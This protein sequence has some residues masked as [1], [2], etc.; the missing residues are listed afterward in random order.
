MY[1]W[2]FPGARLSNNQSVRGNH[3]KSFDPFTTKH[4]TYFFFV[5]NI[6]LFDAPKSYLLKVEDI[7]VDKVVKTRSWKVFTTE[8]TDEFKE[9]ILY[10]T[11]L[12]NANVA[13][14]SIPTVQSNQLFP[15][16]WT[17][18]ASMVST[19]SMILSL[20]SIIMGLL[21]VKQQRKGGQYADEA[22]TF[23]ETRGHLTRGSE[24]LAILLSLPYIFLMFA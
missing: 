7:Y 3:P 12:L 9:Y 16:L 20:G 15:E 14:L 13:Y 10:G 1:L 19:I 22:V 24:M 8:M 18:S 21:L 4:R 11:V 6:L 23:L 5:I 17:S 2:G